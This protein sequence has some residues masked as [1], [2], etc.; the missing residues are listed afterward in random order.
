MNLGGS[1]AGV[2]AVHDAELAQA[3]AEIPD[4]ALQTLPWYTS[5]RRDRLVTAGLCI[6]F[7]VVLLFVAVTLHIRQR[8]GA[9]KASAAAASSASA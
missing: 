5:E 6:G 3:A 2:V 8:L 7:T 9:A 1:D 4:E